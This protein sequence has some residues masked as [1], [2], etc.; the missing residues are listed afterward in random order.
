MRPLPRPWRVRR[1][2]DPPARQWPIEGHQLGTALEPT[3]RSGPGP[4]TGQIY[5]AITNGKGTMQPYASQLSVEER[6][7][8]V[9]YIRALQR[10]QNATTA[11]LPAGVQP[12]ESK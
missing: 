1:W 5:D 10:S 8:V 12:E 7:A 9:A 2:S 11:D 3:E 6:W 4:S